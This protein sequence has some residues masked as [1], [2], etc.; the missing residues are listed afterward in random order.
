MYAISEASTII[1]TVLLTVLATL[2]L[3]LRLLTANRAYKGDTFRF[4]WHVDDFLC[5]AALVSWTFL[6]SFFSLARHI[7][8]HIVRFLL[9]SQIFLYA[10]S[11]MIIWG[12]AM[13]AM[14]SH[15]SPEDAENWYTTAGPAW[16]VLA[17]TFWVVFFLQ[18]LQLGCIRLAILFLYRRFFGTYKSFNIVN[19]TLV[20]VVSGWTIAFFFGLLFDCGLQ[21]DANWASLG[22]I[23]QQC[24]FGFLPTV[25][26]TILDACLD[27]FVLL[28]PIP[29]IFQLNLSLTNKL[30]ITG[31][32]LL[33]SIATAA[34]FVRMT[35]FIQTGIPS[36]AM[37]RT[38]V[39]GLPAYDLLG[40]VS[41]EVFWTMIEST[42]ALIA[43]CL[44]AVRKAVAKSAFGKALGFASFSRMMRSGGSSPSPSKITIRS[45][46]PD[47][48]RCSNCSGK[49]PVGHVVEVSVESPL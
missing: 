30:S 3:S 10:S 35:V 1:L 16:I 13:G 41:A 14:G 49:I 38:T 6:S 22:E 19:W 31:C 29:W 25:I 20:A 5:V 32:F 11:A 12:A 48:N 7:A 23:A 43:V 24:P 33:G 40:I 15:S 8:D 28:L 4:R 9:L 27:L 47:D 34:A 36:E 37:N 46:S 26:Y 2:A 17:K 21:M 45:E 39:M 44:P 42:V 18:P